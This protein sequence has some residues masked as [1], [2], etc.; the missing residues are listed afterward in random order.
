MTKIVRDIAYVRSGDKGDIVHDRRD[1]A[2]AGGLSD[3]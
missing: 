2:H 3:P 1:R